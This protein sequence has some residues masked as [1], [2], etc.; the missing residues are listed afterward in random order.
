MSEVKDRLAEVER[1]AVQND[2]NVRYVLVTLD[3]HGKTL[4]K[5]TRILD[6]HT[7]ILDQHTRILDEHTEQFRLI[8]AEIDQHT[9]ILEGH[10]RLHNEHT[11]QFRLIGEKLVEHSQELAWL[12]RASAK[13]M[14]FFGI[15]GPEEE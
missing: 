9:V 4:D 12:R 8:R 11:E 14:D 2:E 10:T 1:R 7:V 13:T 3:K 5:H 6:E 15:E